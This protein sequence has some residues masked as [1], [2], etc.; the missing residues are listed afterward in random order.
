MDVLSKCDVFLVWGLGQKGL[1]MDFIFNKAVR[2]YFLPTFV[3]V[4][5]YLFKL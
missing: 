1:C 4:K 5:M 2:A 3:S